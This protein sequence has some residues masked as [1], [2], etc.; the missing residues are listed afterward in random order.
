[1]Y[2]E[3]RERCQKEDGRNERSPLERGD[4]C[5]VWIGDAFECIHRAIL[6]FPGEAGQT[7]RWEGW[8]GRRSQ[9]VSRHPA[10]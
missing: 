9:Q 4:N 7:I 10:R 8:R 6:V 3:V 2:L 5:L 1:M